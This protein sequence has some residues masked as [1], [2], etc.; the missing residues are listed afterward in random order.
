[1]KD[2]TTSRLMSVFVFLLASSLLT[3]QLPF[4]GN[5]A[6]SLL[7]TIEVGVQSRVWNEELIQWVQ[8]LCKRGN[9]FEESF[10]EYDHL[11]DSIRFRFNCSVTLRL[12]EVVLIMDGKGQTRFRF[13]PSKSC[14][15]YTKPLAGM[16]RLV[17][18]DES[19]R[20]KVLYFEFI[21]VDELPYYLR[22]VEGS[23][24]IHPSKELE[25]AMDLKDKDLRKREYSVYYDEDNNTIIWYNFFTSKKKPSIQASL[26]LEYLMEK[27]GILEAL[28]SGEEPF[29]LINFSFE[30]YPVDEFRLVPVKKNS[31]SGLR[32]P[33][34]NTFRFLEIIYLEGN[35]PNET[36]LPEV[37]VTWMLSER[38]GS[39]VLV[40]VKEPKY[41][42]NATV[43]GEGKILMDPPGGV[44][45]EGIEVNIRAVPAKGY[46]FIRWE[47]DVRGEHP[48][49]TLVMN[50]NKSITAY[51]E[52]VNNCKVFVSVEPE[53]SGEVVFTPANDTYPLGTD[54]VIIAL[55]SKGYMF[56]HWE[57]DIEGR[58]NPV[59]ITLDSDKYL[60]AFFKPG[61]ID[62]RKPRIGYLQFRDKPIFKIGVSIIIGKFTIELDASDE[63]DHVSFYLDGNQTFDDR[64]R[65]FSWLCDAP[66]GLRTITILAFDTEENL[67][68]AETFYV[69]VI[70]LSR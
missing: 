38:W 37:N 7:Y 57:G 15:L 55:P 17:P 3:P 21:G 14:D 56:D 69:F 30:A 63:V 23:A 47:G 52:K 40:R 49:V 31:S 60:K 1:M 61:G 28:R 45:H 13:V 65:P 19:K 54:V 8:T 2:I 42:I 41:Y 10:L 46:R 44:Y 9:P 18:V 68:D 32:P 35:K 25:K 58:F 48:E 53:G 33:K 16:G 62:I 64:E 4:N 39:H 6:P 34:P 22:Y 70:N 66:F 27:S 29:Y 12:R 36:D 5:S 50:S 51:F 43:E 26:E 59:K 67:I 20:K 24:K 11:G